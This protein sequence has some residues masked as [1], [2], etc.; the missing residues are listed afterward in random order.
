MSKTCQNIVYYCGI[1]DC[2]LQLSKTYK[3]YLKTT[4]SDKKIGQIRTIAIFNTK[5]K[6]TYSDYQSILK[7][8]EFV[9]IA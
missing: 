9:K 8:K 3:K 2:G 6:Q 1:E 4:K 7:M 5:Y